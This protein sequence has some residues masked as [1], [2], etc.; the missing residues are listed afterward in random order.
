MV[1]PAGRETRGETRCAEYLGRK[2]DIENEMRMPLAR[3]HLLFHSLRISYYYNKR[4][5]LYCT[6]YDMKRYSDYTVK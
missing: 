3:V 1:A 6:L 4:N 2:L 5:R